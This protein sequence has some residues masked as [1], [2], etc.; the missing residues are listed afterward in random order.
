MKKIKRQLFAVIC[1]AYTG[2]HVICGAFVSKEEAKEWEK[3]TEIDMCPIPHK[4]K[5]GTITLV[6]P[7]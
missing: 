1:S 6:M 5:K 3:K 2:Q 4:I 7:K